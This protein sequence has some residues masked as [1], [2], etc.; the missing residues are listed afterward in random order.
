MDGK[1]AAAFIIVAGSVPQRREKVAE[2]PDSVVDNV[3][4]LRRAWEDYFPKATRNSR[5]FDTRL[6]RS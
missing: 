5:F 2:L 3:D 1:Y 6:T 4:R